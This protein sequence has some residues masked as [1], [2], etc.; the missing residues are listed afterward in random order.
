MGDEAAFA[1]LG[2][3]LNLEAIPSYEVIT[4]E[5]LSELLPKEEKEDKK[6][7]KKD[8]FKIASRTIIDVRSS[9]REGGHIPGSLNIPSDE[10][11]EKISSLVNA[12][13]SF[14]EGQKKPSHLI[15]HCMYSRERGP[16]CALTF[17]AAFK[18]AYSDA[19]PPTVSVLKGGF[20]G[21]L[22]MLVEGGAIDSSLEV[23]KASY[24]QSFDK[25]KWVKTDEQGLI[26]KTDFEG[27]EFSSEHAAL[28]FLAPKAS[29][30][31]AAAA[32]AAAAAADGGGG[33][34]ASSG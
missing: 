7:E 25:S 17:V 16:S 32:A 9:D 11:E 10:F 8:G 22:N 12:V 4:A 2:L 26:Y 20:N 24:I 28:R 14:Q 19:T 1:P 21:W 31:H 29:P 6:S 27:E 34:V 13:Q 30:R 3:R 15:F 18:E 5:E 23:K 33:A